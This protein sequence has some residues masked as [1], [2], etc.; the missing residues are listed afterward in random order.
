MR[1]PDRRKQRREYLK[2]K[3]VAQSK[4]QGGSLLALG[5]LIAAI[6][7]GLFTCGYLL[8]AYFLQEGTL[9]LLALL[10]TVLAIVCGSGCR[11]ISAFIEKASNEEMSIPYVPPVTPDTLSA[12]EVLVR[13]SQEPLQEQRTILLRAAVENADR[14]E[15]EL[16]RAAEKRR[17]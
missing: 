4:I 6:I 9:L 12:E 7:S 10:F 1:L 16:L 11:R 14:P 15:E 2:R 17:S 3:V 13:G 5:L 8:Y